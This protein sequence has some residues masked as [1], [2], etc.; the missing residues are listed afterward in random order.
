M[1]A[2]PTRKLE[3]WRYSDIDAVAR[4]WP[5]APEVLTVAP[6]TSAAQMVA[7]DAVP[8]SATITSAAVRAAA[9]VSGSE[10]TLLMIAPL[11]SRRLRRL[12]GGPATPPPPPPQSSAA[13][14]TVL[15][16]IQLSARL[17]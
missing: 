1:T 9:Q 6:G 2:L 16:V 14:D 5:V 8:G 10:R 7:D 4:V 11:R 3:D 17:C 13:G 15:E 12:L